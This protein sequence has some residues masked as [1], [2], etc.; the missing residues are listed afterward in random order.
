MTLSLAVAVVTTLLTISGLFYL[1]LALLAARAFS[2]TPRA[3]LSGPA[4][5]VTILKPIK[6]VDPGMAASFRSACLQRYSGRY[7]LLLGVGEDDAAIAALVDS[8]TREFPQVP[9]RMVVCS[10]RL[11]ASGKVSTLAQMLPHA[12]GEV[13]VINDA[14]IRM[15]PNYLQQVAA[16]LTQAGVAMVTAP[17]LGRTAEKPT[18]WARLEALGIATELMPGV[19][20]ARMMERG[21]RFG[22]GSTLA[23][24]RETLAAIGGLEALLDEVADDYEIGARVHRSGGRVVLM[25]EV[26]ETSVPQYDGRGFFQHQIRWSR[27]VR[28][29]RPWSYLGLVSAYAVP[30]ALLNVVATGFWLPSFTLLSLVLL[31]RVAGALTVGV[32]LLGDGQVLRDVALLPVRDCVSLALWAWSYASDEVVWRGERFLLRGGRMQPLPAKPS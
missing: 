5:T 29:A 7:E 28:D 22:L 24:R 18:V 32:G 25:R 3:T 1:L 13:I 31:A 19:L 4:P 20:T 8:L 15:G 21:M 26:V 27:T 11:G 23:L 9:V 10:Q 16:E 12:L 30:W 17:Y 2:R 14:D 6:G